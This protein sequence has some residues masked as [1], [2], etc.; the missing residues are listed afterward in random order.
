MKYN[1]LE[2]I[3]NLIKI[4]GILMLTIKNYNSDIPKA[5]HLTLR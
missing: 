2:I 3:S 5:V 1:K 4:S